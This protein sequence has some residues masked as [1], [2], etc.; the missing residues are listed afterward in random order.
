MVSAEKPLHSQGA[1]HTQMNIP[2]APRLK[3]SMPS[4]HL[5]FGPISITNSRC[6]HRSTDFHFSFPATPSHVGECPGVGGGQPMKENE[7][8]HQ[9]ANLAGLRHYP[10]Q[11]AGNKKPV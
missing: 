9:V 3:N 6:E 11:V 2:A 5:S 10:Q 4:V 8:L 7:Y 1:S